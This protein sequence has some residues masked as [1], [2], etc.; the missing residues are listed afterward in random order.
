[1]TNDIDANENVIYQTILNNCTHPVVLI[2]KAEYNRTGVLT[3]ELKTVL[4]IKL[5]GGVYE[6]EEEVLEAKT[7]SSVSVRDYTKPGNPIVEVTP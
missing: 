2:V 4:D 5:K 3:D 6:E 7:N 1:M